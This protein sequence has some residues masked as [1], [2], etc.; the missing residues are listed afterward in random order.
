MW[1]LLLVCSGFIDSPTYNSSYLRLIEAF[2]L[3][4]DP[5]LV[6]AKFGLLTRDDGGSFDKMSLDALV[7]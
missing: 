5:I 2:N 6:A 3:N 4:W 7:V 1:R